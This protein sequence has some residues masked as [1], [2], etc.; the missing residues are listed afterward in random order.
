M[1]I[2]ISGMLHSMKLIQQWWHVIIAKTMH[3]YSTNIQN[4]WQTHRLVMH[5][6]ILELKTIL[7]TN[8]FGIPSYHVLKN[9]L[10]HLIANAPKVC[11]KLSMEQA[12]CSSKTTNYGSPLNQNFSMTATSDI[13]LS[14]KPQISSLCLLVA[15]VVQINLLNNSK[16]SS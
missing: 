4:I 7:E 5:F 12:I 3:L 2:P 1:I 16:K 10:K 8:T 6:M 11:G 15:N 13:S 14:K 9:K